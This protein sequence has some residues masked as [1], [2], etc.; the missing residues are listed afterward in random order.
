MRAGGHDEA[1]RRVTR[2]RERVQKLVVRIMQ[3]TGGTPQ[4]ND[5]YKFEDRMLIP[6][7]RHHFQTDFRAHRGS[8]LNTVSRR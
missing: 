5:S 2:L 7:T 8:L 1:N 6:L 4:Y 3:I